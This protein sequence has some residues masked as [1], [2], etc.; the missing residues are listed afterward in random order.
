MLTAAEAREIVGKNTR[1]AEELELIGKLIEH[2]AR[3]GKTS[4]NFYF[5]ELNSFQIHAAVSE[6]IRLGYTVNYDWDD[7]RKIWIDWE[8]VRLQREQ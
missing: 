1:V 5:T 4:A 3:A 7:P 8:I 2:T 6:L